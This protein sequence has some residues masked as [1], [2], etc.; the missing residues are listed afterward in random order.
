MKRIKMVGII[1]AGC[2]VI[3]YLAMLLDIV[4]L[5][6]N[7]KSVFLNE[8]SS[9]DQYCLERY[10]TSRYGVNVQRKVTLFPLLAF[11]NFH[12]GYVYIY[13]SNGVYDD[14]RNLLHGSTSILSKWIIEK[15]NGVWR[16][17][18]IVEAP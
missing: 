14:N 11:H 3:T 7:A 10:D 17:I 13:Y 9:N 12:Q 16:V 6:Q 8:I 5:V 1:L 4:P 15:V 2:I 18:D